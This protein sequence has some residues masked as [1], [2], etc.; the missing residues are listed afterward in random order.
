MLQLQLNDRM[1]YFV[2]IELYKNLYCWRFN[3][4][5]NREAKHLITANSMLDHF[6][7]SFNNPTKKNATV[8]DSEASE[9]SYFTL[10]F[11]DNN[12]N[13]LL[14]VFVFF[15]VFITDNNL[16]SYK[17]RYPMCRSCIPT[18]SGI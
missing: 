3:G 11:W 8:K 12:V 1:E 6:I 15:C 10:S 13:F 14:F 16:N 5:S 18:P 4:V 9:I 2:L 7:F 17:R